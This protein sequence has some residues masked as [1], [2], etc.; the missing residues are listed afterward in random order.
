MQN[1]WGV[2]AAAAPKAATGLVLKSGTVRHRQSRPRCNVDGA[3]VSERAVDGERTTACEIECAEIG[4]C[5]AACGGSP[6][7]CRSH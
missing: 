2:V 7:L 6:F 3:G 4:Y 5:D 1:T